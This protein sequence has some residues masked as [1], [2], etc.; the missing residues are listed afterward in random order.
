M[1][2]AVHLLPRFGHGRLPGSRCLEGGPSAGRGA[3]QGLQAAAVVAGRAAPH[4]RQRELV[5]RLVYVLLRALVSLAREG[6]GQGP[7]PGHADDEVGLRYRRQP[8]H[9]RPTLGRLRAPGEVAR[10]PRGERRQRTLAPRR[11][12]DPRAR[13]RHRPRGPRCRT[14]GPPRRAERPRAGAPR[15][16]AREHPTQRPRGAVSDLAPRLG[17]RRPT[18]AEREAAA[19]EVQ[20]RGRRGPHLRGSIR[21]RA[22]RRRAQ[23]R[24]AFRRRRLLRQRD[25]PPQ[26]RDL[27]LGRRAAGGRLRGPG[28]DILLRRSLART[29]L[30][31]AR[32]RPGV[33][34]L[35]SPSTTEHGG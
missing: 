30:R 9:G 29:A 17:R 8:P 20:R 6:C 27:V 15:R 21:R 33:L 11:R 10:E 13:R 26:G 7:A 1:P 12:P 4:G 5:G 18:G 23:A 2:A 14:A 24:S 22:R 32:A 28:G 34:L 35:R 25:P 16:V 19:P 31:R 3:G